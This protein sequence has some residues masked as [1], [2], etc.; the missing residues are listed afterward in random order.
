MGMF[1]ASYCGIASG[2]SSGGDLGVVIG[3]DGRR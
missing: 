3:D 1:P 2:S